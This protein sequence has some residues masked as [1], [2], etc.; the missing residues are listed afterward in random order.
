MSEPEIIRPRPDDYRSAWVHA[1]DRSIKHQLELAQAM[2]DIESVQ[3]AN[4]DR[5]ESV[6]GQLDK[7]LIL[8]DQ[9]R[10]AV[11]S[12]LQQAAAAY[13]EMFIESIQYADGQIHR[14]VEEA[15][16]KLVDHQAQFAS[17]ISGQA[18][19]LEAE[20]RSL[21]LQR[22]EIAAARASLDSE[23][24]RLQNKSGFFQRFLK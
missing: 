24:I 4:V 16:A 8:I 3:A 1:L 7:Q 10:P 19:Q 11:S 14:A 20:R 15:R 12:M 17:Q 5:L 18:A 13:R 21:D 23:R 2:A 9:L 6:T 22:Q